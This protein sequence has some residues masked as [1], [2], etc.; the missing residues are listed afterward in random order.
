MLG[1]R[2]LKLKFE[3]K[4]I[5]PAFIY[6]IGEVMNNVEYFSCALRDYQFLYTHF[7]CINEFTDK[8]SLETIK[9]NK[10]NKRQEKSKQ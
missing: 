9:T 3:I 1:N 2:L 6:F 10:Q 4:K 7:L 8:Y 5:P